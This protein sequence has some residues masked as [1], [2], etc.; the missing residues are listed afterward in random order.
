[1][2]L[3]FELIVA[4]SCLKSGALKI[5][6]IISNG[7]SSSSKIAPVSAVSGSTFEILT[8][9]LF[10]SGGCY[11]ATPIQVIVTA[12]VEI[13]TEGKSKLLVLECSDVEVT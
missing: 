4:N 11:C 6:F 12:P 8:S 9:E 2:G 7:T 1:M 5:T 3:S 10:A 13:I